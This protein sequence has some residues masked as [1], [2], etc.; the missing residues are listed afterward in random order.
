MPA[1]YPLHPAFDPRSGRTGCR[2]R[3]RWGTARARIV[4]GRRGGGRDGR[5]P[6]RPPAPTGT[7][8]SRPSARA[9]SRE[10]AAAKRNRSQE[11]EDGVDDLALV[12]LARASAGAS[13]GDHGR[14]RGPLG[15]GQIGGVGAAARQGVDPGTMRVDAS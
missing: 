14:D 6:R 8:N 10:A 12:G 5:G 1:S 9:G 11:V 4:P 15:V 13:L 7:D 3:R 2:A